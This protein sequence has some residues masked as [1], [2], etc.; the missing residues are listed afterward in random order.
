MASTSGSCFSG[1]LLVVLILS[2]SQAQDFSLEV[3]SKSQSEIE[4][5]LT[6]LN[7]SATIQSIDSIECAKESDGTA[8]PNSPNVLIS[9]SNAN[10]PFDF[11][12]IGESYRFS[13]SSIV[14]TLNGANQMDSAEVSLESCTVPTTPTDD[15]DW[16]SLSII[17]GTNFELPDSA[18]NYEITLV[19]TFCT[20]NRTLVHY[21]GYPPIIYY[22]QTGCEYRILYANRCETSSGE[23]TPSEYVEFSETFCTAPE[24]PVPASSLTLVNF[25]ETMIEISG[26]G[27]SSGEYEAIEV[28]FSTG[29]GCPGG[30]ILRNLSTGETDLK[31]EDL[32]PGCLY[33]LK[34]S[35][36]CHADQGSAESATR[37]AT[38]GDTL[39]TIPREIETSSLF[40]T[41]TANSI[42]IQAASLRVQAVEGNLYR[43]KVKTVTPNGSY[44]VDAP[45]PDTGTLTV[46]LLSPATKYEFELENENLCDEVS[47]LST[48]YAACTL[49]T[50][51]EKSSIQVECD[52]T[53]VIIKGTVSNVQANIGPLD[54]YRINSVNSI[55]PTTADLAAKNADL[56]VPGLESGTVYEIKVATV[57]DTIAD[58]DT[59]ES[60]E[61]TTIRVCT[62]LAGVLDSLTLSDSTATSLTISGFGVTSGSFTSLKIT[63]QGI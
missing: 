11:L 61:Q 25:T 47:K 53:S 62:K 27:V 8:C 56:E 51:P 30:P 31:A 34:Y 21:E 43:F 33:T 48:Q 29:S 3:V 10:L 9:G 13:V 28:E 4:I 16:Y 50:A 24:T 46:S 26:F 1:M 40:H 19:P 6:M 58:C 38:L 54:S 35:A 36:V 2:K 63:L 7:S 44:D 22:V 12:G 59:L 42:S 60:S 41:A 57:V 17:D 18:N 52:L 32:I 14:Y 37:Q 5:Q 39:C 49:P 45:Q 23:I 55:S 15:V 20:G